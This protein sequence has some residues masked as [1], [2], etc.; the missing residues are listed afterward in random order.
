MVAV[1]VVE[2]EVGSE[3]MRVLV[4][5]LVEVMVE[6]MSVLVMVVVVGAHFR[7][8]YSHLES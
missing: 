4:V 8:L 3:V 7:L 2:E 5:E 1:G 6:V